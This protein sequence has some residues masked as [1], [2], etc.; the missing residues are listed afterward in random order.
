MP[1]PESRPVA[2]PDGTVFHRDPEIHSGTPVFVGTRVPVQTFVEYLE[3]GTT[4]TSFWITSLACGAS[5]PSDSWRWPPK[6]LSRE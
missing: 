3:G 4:S 1:D 2:L 6:R 5:R